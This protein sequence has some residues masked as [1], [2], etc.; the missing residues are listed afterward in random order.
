[1]QGEKNCVQHDVKL[2]PNQLSSHTHPS[3][4]QP[5][6]HFLWDDTKLAVNKGRDYHRTST[7]TLQGGGV[8]NRSLQRQPRVNGAV[9]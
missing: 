2:R 4:E 9:I 5:R 6:Q 3:T 7:R 1:M 8:S